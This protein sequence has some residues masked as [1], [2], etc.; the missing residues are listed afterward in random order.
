MEEQTV[1]VEAAIGGIVIVILT[2]RPPVSAIRAIAKIPT[3]R[4]F[5]PKALGLTL[6]LR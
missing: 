6:V 3:G 1:I 4:N 5:A 2:T